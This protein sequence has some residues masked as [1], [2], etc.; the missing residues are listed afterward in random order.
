MNTN[1]NQNQQVTPTPPPIIQYF[2]LINNQQQG[3]FDFQQLQLM[4]TQAA[5]KQETLVWKQG[6][7]NWSLGPHYS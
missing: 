2:V 1:L 6:M 4:V 5:I 3:P 7:A